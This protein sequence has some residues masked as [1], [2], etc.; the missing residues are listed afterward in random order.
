ME[1]TSIELYENGVDFVCK[2]PKILPSA[3]IASPQ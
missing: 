2:T 3:F 1:L